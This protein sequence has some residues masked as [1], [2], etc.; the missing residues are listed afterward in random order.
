MHKF[1]AKM[2]LWSILILVGR[3]YGHTL[4]TGIVGTRITYHHRTLHPYS[5]T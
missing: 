1:D 3:R 5:T 4:Y 2:H